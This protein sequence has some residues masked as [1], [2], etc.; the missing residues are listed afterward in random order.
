MSLRYQSVTDCFDT[1]Y[2]PIPGSFQ[3]RTQTKYNFAIKSST[4]LFCF[5]LLLCEFLRWLETWEIYLLRHKSFHNKF[6]DL[7]EVIFDRSRAL[8]LHVKKNFEENVT[9]A[10]QEM[11]LAIER[12]MPAQALH[13]K[14][15]LFASKKEKK[16]RGPLGDEIPK[17]RNMYET[18]SKMFSMLRKLGKSKSV[19]IGDIPG[20]EIIEMKHIDVGTLTPGENEVVHVKLVDETLLPQ[21]KISDYDVTAER[22][23]LSK[24]AHALH[25]GAIEVIFNSYASPDSD[26]VGGMLLVDTHHT[27]LENAIRSVFVTSL[28]GG[29]PIRVLMFPNTLV[30]IGPEMNDRFKLLCTTSNGDISKGKNLAAVK[31]NIVGCTVGLHSTYTPS[32][33]LEQE[34]NV[35]RGTVTEYLGRTSFVT[36][37]INTITED[38]M[39]EQKFQFDLPAIGSSSRRLSFSL[40]GKG[41]LET[42]EQQSLKEKIPTLKKI[43]EKLSETALVDPV[44]GEVQISYG[45][46]SVES[47]LTTTFAQDPVVSE[48]YL[49]K[50]IAQTKVV[51]PKIL[52]G[53]T[54]LL[55]EKLADLLITTNLRMT[56][57]FKRTHVQKQKLVALATVGVPENTGLCLM[58]CYNS[59]IRGKATVDAYTASSQASHIWN[60]ACKQSARLEIAPNPVKK[61]WSYQYLRMSSCHFSVVCISGW[62]ATPLTN[63]SMTID[64]FLSNDECEAD[65]YCLG[66]YNPTLRLNRWM[67]RLTFPQGTDVVA[68][69]MPL[70]IGGGAGGTGVV[71]INMPNALS[72]MWRYIMGGMKFDVI[73]MSS[74]YIKSTIAFLIA[75]TDVDATTVD[76][77]DYP[78]RLVQFGEVQERVTIDFRPEE[79]AMAWSSQVRNNTPIS[80]EGCPY[81]Y[82]ITHDSTGSTI[83]GDFNIG[84]VLKEMYQFSGIGRNPGWTGARPLS[85]EAQ[86]VR[87]TKKGV[88]NKLY[89]IRVPPE[90]KAD[91]VMVLSIDLIGVGIATAGKGTWSLATINSPMNNLLR[92]AT[93]KTGTLKFQLIMEGNVTV[94]RSDWASYVEV[95]LRQSRSDKALSTREWTM[96]DP[97]SWEL[98]FELEL[99][100]PN[101]GFESWEDQFSNQTGWFLECVVYNPDQA[102]VYTVNGYVEDDFCCA[103]NTL[104]PGFLEPSNV[105]TRTRS[106]LGSAEYD[107]NINNTLKTPSTS[108]EKPALAEYVG[109][110]KGR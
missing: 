26:I 65:I 67:G 5:T 76:I 109:A 27:K 12:G 100:G 73:K 39:R 22:N 23:T 110:S 56:G 58:M 34:L 35:E 45:Q 6:F 36:H 19:S 4:L 87:T 74:P 15:T 69:R 33:F 83:A 30:E 107:Y 1:I 59:S 91:D 97:H 43:N 20:N 2:T 95:S 7:F 51:L 25:V 29:K 37:N 68:R 108:L 41:L 86:G 46:A 17:G 31:V 48:P 42:A 84:V 101:N 38:K 70:A 66:G 71:Y 81:L 52:Q 88:Y 90:A 55:K 50:R 61:E 11:E 98:E 53:G 18:N 79:F 104:M 57:A 62:T 40:A 24:R 16:A 13:L 85:A 54:I 47:S 102:T 106:R 14:E 72:S 49:H 28:A 9:V 78:H 21:P 75:F 92:T 3:E 60:P 105:N 10:A 44:D 64:W 32:K 99:L 94:K 103:G 93:W 82:A 8:Q 96:K 77:E 63:I 89:E 80:E